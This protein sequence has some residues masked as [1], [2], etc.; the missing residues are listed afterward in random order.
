M[1]KERSRGRGERKEARE[2]QRRGGREKRRRKTVNQEFSTVV[3]R[4]IPSPLIPSS[5]PSSL[6]LSAR[7]VSG[8]HG[9]D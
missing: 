7:A 5:S 6:T 3:E 2:R 4:P 9:I 1:N 8:E